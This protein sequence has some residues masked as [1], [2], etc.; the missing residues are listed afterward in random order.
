[1]KKAPYRFP[2]SVLFALVGLASLAGC[3][4][5]SD[6]EVFQVK[7]FSPEKGTA[8]GG[9]T[10]KVTG[11][12]FDT[13]AMVYFGQTKAASVTRVSGEL[14]EVETPPHLAGLVDL[15][16]RSKEETAILPQAFEFTPLNLSFR[17]A[18]AWYLPEYDG[19]IEDAIAEDFNGDGYPDLLYSYR[20]EPARL[21]PNSKGSFAGAVSS[22]SEN[23]AGSPVDA[24]DAS[25]AGA[26]APV[27]DASPP[28]SGV[29]KGSGTWVRDTTRMLALD[30]DKDGDMDVLL[31]NRSGQPHALMLNNGDGTFTA[32]ANAFPITSDECLDATLADIDHDGLLD[33]VVLGRGKVGSG[34]SYL[35][36]YRQKT[37]DSPSF[38][39]A[40]SLEAD[41]PSADGACATLS[42]SSA[43]VSVSSAISRTT[44]AQ[45]T[46][47][48]QVKYEDGTIGSTVGAWLTLPSLPTLP[49]F[50]QFKIRSGAGPLGLVVRI[51][52]AQDEVFRY[53]AGTFDAS[54]WKSIS[55]SKLGSWTRE[56]DGEGP[57]A[58]PLKAVG[59]LVSLSAT[60]PAGHFLL[61]DFVVDVPA[62]GKVV[63]DD[64]ERNTFLHA[65]QERRNN[66]SAGDMDG[67]GYPDLLIGSSVAGNH[68]PLLLLLNRYA[69]VESVAFREVL[70]GPL[71]SLG[72]PVTS[73]AALDVDDDGHLDLIAAVNGDQNAY[74]VGDGNGYFF[75]DTLAMMPLD[76]VNTV[77]L[78]SADLDMDG[79]MDILLANDGSRDR[80]YLG[81][82][83]KRFSDETP[84]LPDVLKR[85]K[86]LLVFDMDGDGDLDIFGL[87]FDEPPVMF[88]SVEEKKP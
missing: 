35:R 78:T 57:V 51:R 6:N 31:C 43:E 15:T 50:V 3:S 25:D 87:G 55:A 88:V 73:T 32:A 71:S 5:S 48:C 39:L 84:K 74:F 70:S 58:L 33:F 29:P 22:P 11:T 18:P 75:D 60:A 83:A 21:L 23:D 27:K 56:S 52:D 72:G 45:G 28:D 46:A 85:T 37:G 64:F 61:D 34:K 47:S 76:R 12:G 67:D 40:E 30:I 66:V 62:I 1:M 44:V 86:K 13:Y 68:S 79:C 49:D 2:S 17:Q 41:D 26:D 8:R 16:V 81:R 19:P 20:N 80:V 53:D 10:M 77:S 69:A 14:L 65:W 9:E 36:V 82:G 7:A 42:A 59:V 54:A 63:V 4:S 24:G 38:S